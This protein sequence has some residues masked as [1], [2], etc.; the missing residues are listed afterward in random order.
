MYIR[1][2]YTR[3]TIAFHL[4]DL[5]PYKMTVFVWYL[6][7]YLQEPLSCFAQLAVRETCSTFLLQDQVVLAFSAT[8]NPTNELIFCGLT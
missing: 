8:V 4:L 3:E 6:A 2:T 5:P 7:L 1:F